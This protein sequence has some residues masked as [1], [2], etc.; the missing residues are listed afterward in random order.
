[1]VSILQIA[2]FLVS[3]LF[4]TYILRKLLV[5]KLNHQ[6]ATTLWWVLRPLDKLAR[7]Q[8]S[9]HI[10]RTLEDME[11]DD[12]QIKI[13]DPT[14]ESGLPHTSDAHT[15]RMTEDVWNSATRD[16]TLKHERVHILQRRYPAE[17]RRFYEEHWGYTLHTEPPTSLPSSDALRLRANPDTATDPWV[18][19][20]NRYWFAPLYSNTENP[21]L[22]G[23][24]IQVWDSEAHVWL[25]EPPE[26]WRRLFCGDGKCP[27]QWEHPHEIAA[28]LWTADAFHTPAGYSLK[29]FM[30]QLLSLQ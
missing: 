7:Q 30:H 1:M 8:N 29:N 18:S 20:M 2:V 28:E 15:I 13:V 27:H 23:V 4:V 19:W 3:T 24:S 9:C 6:N 17:W 10:L 25:S 12:C 11:L 22:L 21:T 14:C 16:S 26:D 5:Q